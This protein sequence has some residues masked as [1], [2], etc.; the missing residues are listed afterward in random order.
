M[1]HHGTLDC[2]GLMLL[3]CRL[4]AMRIE[5]MVLCPD[6]EYGIISW[7]LQSMIKDQKEQEDQAP[8]QI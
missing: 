7:T 3:F 1:T 8:G 6:E 2:N 4:L 5:V